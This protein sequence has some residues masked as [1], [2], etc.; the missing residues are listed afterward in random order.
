[1][2]CK[3]TGG[4]LEELWVGMV[5]P[6]F[7]EEFTIGIDALDGHLILNSVSVSNENLFNDG[8]IVIH[9]VHNVLQP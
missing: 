8:S 2:P 4:D 9:G 1:M 6:T 7:A 3:L 5:V